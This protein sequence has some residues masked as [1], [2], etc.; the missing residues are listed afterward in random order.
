M[1]SGKKSGGRG[2]TWVGS[3]DRGKPSV[4]FWGLAALDPSHS[5]DKMS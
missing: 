4:F 3:A 1:I 2:L 5:P